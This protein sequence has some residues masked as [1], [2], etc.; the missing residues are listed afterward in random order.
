MNF[1]EPKGLLVEGVTSQGETNE[2]TENKYN[3]FILID[4]FKI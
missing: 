1:I 3:E 2:D 4:P